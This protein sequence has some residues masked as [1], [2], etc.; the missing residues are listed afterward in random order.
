MFQLYC[1][2]IY[3]LA[4][5]LSTQK[6]NQTIKSNDKVS[7][8]MELLSPNVTS[9]EMDV[10]ACY[11]YLRSLNANATSSLEFSADLD[12]QNELLN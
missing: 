1:T 2:K 6:L 5:T 3:I 10:D 9:I 4:F 7:F 8:I 11:T 12:R